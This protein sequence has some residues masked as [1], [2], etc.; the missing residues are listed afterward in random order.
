MARS[1]S[2]LGCAATSLQTGMTK[3][4]LL[5]MLC[6]YKLAENSRVCRYGFYT[7][8][9][10]DFILA[11]ESH[12]LIKKFLAKEHLQLSTEN[13][14]QGKNFRAIL[15]NCEEDWK[16]VG[17]LHIGI[18]AVRTILNYLFFE[19]TDFQLREIYLLKNRVLKTHTL[20]VYFRMC[21][22]LVVP[23]VLKRQAFSLF[24]SHL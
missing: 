6:V 2:L 5:L 22:N 10:A 14:F 8:K 20:W 15:V 21:S 19:S 7:F 3:E 24:F 17:I 13:T 1:W 11:P 16:K 4:Y 12:C 9:L 18:I 23:D